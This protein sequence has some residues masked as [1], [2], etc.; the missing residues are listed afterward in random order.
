LTHKKEIKYIAKEFNK[1]PKAKRESKLLFLLKIAIAAIVLQTVSFGIII[2]AL[3]IKP[4]PVLTVNQKTGELIGEY[5][6]TAF[7]TNAELIAGAKRFTKYH[8]SFNSSTVYDDFA[9]ALNMM[10]DKLRQERIAYL[11]K[12]NLARDIKSA[13]S[14]SHLEF[15][16][17]RI[18]E[19]KGK[20]AKVE[21]SGNLVIGD[22]SIV[23]NDTLV[24]R[25]NVPFRILI[26]LKMV[27]VSNVNTAG[28]KVVDYYEYK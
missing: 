16:L 24:V 15:E 6:T 20:F 1:G 12:S 13:N 27:Q 2:G 10:S 5:Q 4:E 23:S 28:V 8:L 19:I 18:A 7:R 22:R 17:E 25:K 26:D 9:N 14:T 11:K 3:I 21:L